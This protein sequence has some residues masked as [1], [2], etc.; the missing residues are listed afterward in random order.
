MSSAMPFFLFFQTL[1]ALDEKAQL[2]V[3]YGGFAHF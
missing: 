3:G 2:F 1:D